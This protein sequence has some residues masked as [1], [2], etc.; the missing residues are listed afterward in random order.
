MERQSPAVGVS[1]EIYPNLAAQT[2]DSE[3]KD[4]LALGLWPWVH[5]ASKGEE[6]I[7][8]VTSSSRKIHSSEGGADK[9]SPN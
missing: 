8:I 1:V 7:A 4:A 3:W 6:G 5:H 9:V 2:L